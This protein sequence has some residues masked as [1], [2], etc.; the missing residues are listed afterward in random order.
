MVTGTKTFN[1][2][3]VHSQITGDKYYHIKGWKEYGPEGITFEGGTFGQY[4][5]L[6]LQLAV[7]Q[8]VVYYY[9]PGLMYFLS[10]NY[11]ATWGRAI[12]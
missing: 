5:G 12:E 6:E 9:E 8:N 11:D 4:V 7:S 2:A 3:L 1:Y 10:Q